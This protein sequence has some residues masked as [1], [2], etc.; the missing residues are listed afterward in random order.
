M[1]WSEYKEL[2]EKTLSTQFHC[3]DKKI[4]LLL[5]AVMGILTELDELSDWKDDI[6]RREEI[7]DS[8]WYLALLDRTLN[9]NLDFDNYDL[10]NLSKYGIENDKLVLTLFKKTSFLLDILKKK[11]YYD[12]KIDYDKIS[13]ISIEIHGILYLFCKLNRVDIYEILEKN[14]NKLRIRYGEKFST[15]K[16]INRDLDKEREELSKYIK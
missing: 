5:H 12:K 10:E 2:S 9:L 15:D 3:D 13:E 14:I 6:N 8:F 7:A 16:A 11:I 1:N 4:E